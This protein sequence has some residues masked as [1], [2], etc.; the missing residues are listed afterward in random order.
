MRIESSTSPLSCHRHPESLNE[1]GRK[2]TFPALLP[3]SSSRA[4]EDNPPQPDVP[5][6]P[7]IAPKPKGSANTWLLSAILAVMVW[8][9]VGHTPQIM[10]AKWEYTIKS[11]PDGSFDEEM[12][13]MGL[14]GWDVVFARRASSGSSSS[15][16]FSYE[17]IFKR[18]K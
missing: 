1:S 2:R 13:K 12:N 10:S 3:V 17:M 7:T 5:A 15:S 8:N 6:T 4:M 18:Q 16:T 9:S 11:V 14:D